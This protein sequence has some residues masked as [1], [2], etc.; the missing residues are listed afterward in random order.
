MSL[1]LNVHIYFKN[2][3]SNIQ[4]KCSHFFENYILFVGQNQML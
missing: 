3:Q 4:P 1:L 2:T